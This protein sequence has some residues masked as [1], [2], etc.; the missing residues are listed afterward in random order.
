MRPPGM[1]P[2]GRASSSEH[3]DDDAMSVLSVEEME[4]FA[5][6]HMSLSSV[7][8]VSIDYVAQ[9][10]NFP[11]NSWRSFKKRG[12]IFSHSAWMVNMWD[13]LLAAFIL[14]TAFYTPLVLVFGDE[15]SW[16]RGA[17][18]GCPGYRC[19]HTGHETFANVIDIIF[20][21]DVIIKA[22]TSYPDHGCA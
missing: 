21:F 12:Y 14:Y 18:Y 22:R 20:L 4:E 16:P 7:A 2:G 8:K 6:R 13:A 19:E 10:R 9:V 11:R 17:A 1:R 15:V 5:R 3:G